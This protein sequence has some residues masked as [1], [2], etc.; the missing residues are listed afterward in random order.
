MR[1]LAAILTATLAL[2]LPPG[3]LAA[4]AAA[5]YALVIGNSRY[6]GGTWRPLDNPRNDVAAI[7]SSLRALGFTIVGCGSTGICLDA[8][9]ATMDKAIQ[10]LGSRLDEHRGAI[11]FVYFSGHG[12]QARRTPES[13]DENFLVPVNSGLEKEFEVAY[14]AIPEQQLLDML[15][16]V[17]VDTGIVVLDACRTNDL[18]RVEKS[19][20]KGLARNAG[21]RG[22]LL[23][24][25][26]EPGQVALD[27]TTGGSLAL[28]PY[29]RRLAE[30]LA[31][32]G[33][34][35]TDV[36]L[37][38]DAQV[39]ADTQGRQRPEAVMRLNHNLVLSAAP[40][41]VPPA[42]ATA[43]PAAPPSA[44]SPDEPRTPADM[45]RRGDDYYFGRNGFPHDDTQAV[46]WYR[47]AA[48]QGDAAAQNG[49]G[50][51]YENGRGGL[52]KSDVEAVRWYRKAAEQ[53]FAHG[54]A[55]LGVMYEYG[56]GGL[57]KSDVEAVRWYR[58]AAEQGDAQGQAYLA[59]MYEHGRGSLAQNDAEAVRL[60]TLAARQGNAYAQKRLKSR[61]LSW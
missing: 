6:E 38:A 33:K 47:K 29:A 20:A 17:G 26:A 55:N 56:R 5:R 23:A 57:A 51:M 28:S 50:F 52:T 32:A 12:V 59:E 37:D 48:E 10:T 44:A 27:S 25:A 24:Y 43:R 35:I 61:G 21:A 41:P 60:Y 11:A 45:N 7:A 53:G 2:T 18:R 8:D 39:A 36:F 19:G 34:P 46:R 40:A 15:A 16:A 31:I 58:K 1:P 4:Q 9:R 14:K 22:V 13:A 30:N 42:A 49:L 54:Q 3:E